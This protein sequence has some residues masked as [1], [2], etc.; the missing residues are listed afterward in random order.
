MHEV[1][2]FKEKN[3]LYLL[4]KG[5]L[6][7]DEV[8]EA[9]NKVKSGINELQPGFAIIN[10]ISEFSPATPKGREIIKETQIYAAQKNVGQV[11]RIVGNVISRIQF[12]RTSQNA[13]YKALSV[14]S[15]QEA[16]D[17]LDGKINIDN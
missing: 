9:A 13:G 8:L 17:Y 1:T 6:K 3:R 16:Y 12:E 5:F 7:D 2:V 15:L 10:D 4:L 14:R 11:I